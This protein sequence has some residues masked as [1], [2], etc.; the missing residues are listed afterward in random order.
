MNEFSIT[1]KISLKEYIQLN[2]A[3]LYKGLYNKAIAIIT[4]LYLCFSGISLLLHIGQHYNDNLYS[5]G[6]LICIVAAVTPILSLIMAY[7]GYSSNK[8][9]QEEITTTFREQDITQSAETFTATFKW[10]KIY[11]VIILGNW[12]LIYKSKIIANFVKFKTED[13]PNIEA[14]KG[15]VET[16]DIRHKW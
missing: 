11:K 15:F 4:V 2:F 7:I 13:K 3:M 5:A 12:L 6:N 16:I 1:Y 9:L 8:T 10:D 14:L